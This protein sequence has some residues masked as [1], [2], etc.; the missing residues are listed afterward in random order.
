MGTSVSA[1]STNTRVASSGQSVTVTTDD[2]DLEVPFDPE[3]KERALRAESSA[4]DVSHAVAAEPGDIPV[5]DMATWIATGDAVELARIAEQVNAACQTAGFFQLTG[6]KVSVDLIAEMFEMNKRFHGL[7]LGIKQ[8]VR[9]DRSDWPITG[10]G[11]LPMYSRKLPSRDKANLNEAFLV[12]GNRDLSLADSQWIGDEYLPGFRSTV[13]RYVDAVN[14]LALQ[15]LPIYAVALGLDPDF[16]APGFDRPSWRLRM[17]HYPP[18]PE[19]LEDDADFGIAPHVD[20]TFFTLLLQ[21][22]AGLMIYSHQ[23]RCWIQAPV[24]PDAFVVNTGELLK[25]WTND[26]YLS[27]RHFANNDAAESRYSIPFFYNAA[28]DYPMECLP[29]CQGPGN[30]PKY[31]TISYEQSQAI[32]QGE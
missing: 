32:A 25:Q 23:R 29:T 10:V 12:K 26:R 3:V 24:V 19:I 9:M 4:W 28:A 27:V 31:P 6:H 16:F 17:T 11:Y 15:M 7:P 8:Q 20:T 30:P 22:A 18:V 21:N 1:A 2:F 5:I 14:E 13:E